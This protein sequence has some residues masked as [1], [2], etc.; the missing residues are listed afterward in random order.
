MRPAWHLAISSLSA[1][2]TR[3]ALLV[4]AVA[5]ASALTVAVA[6]AMGTIE[7]ALRLSAGQMVGL[8]DYRIVHAQA[9]RLPGDLL[10]QVRA[11]PEVDQA[12]GRVSTGVSLRHADN[13]QK[14]T[15]AAV[16]V[17]PDVD[18][19]FHPLRLAAGRAIAGEN[20]IVLDQ[21]V[22]EKLDARLG[23]RLEVIRFGTPI[24]L[25]VVGIVERPPLGV[26]Q[27]MMVYVSLPQAQDIAASGRQVEA[28]SIRL[29]PGVDA[30]QFATDAADRLPVAASL[31]TPAAASARVTRSLKVA[32]LMYVML[33][34]AVFLSTAVIILTGLTTA[35]A[36]QQREIAMVRCIGGSRALAGASRLLSGLC[37]SGAGVLLGGPLG[38]AMSYGFFL[39]HAERLPGGYVLDRGATLLAMAAALGAGLVG[40]AYPALRAAGTAPVGMLAAR[41]RK[42]SAV[43]LALAVVAAAL[44]I[45]L[46][47]TV[48]RLPLD[49]E[50]MFAWHLRVALPAMFVGYVLLGVVVFAAVA[51]LLSPL[52]AMM[53]RMPAGLLRE[54]A[55][56]TPFRHGLTA[57][58]LMVSLAMLVGM[59]SS[60]RSVMVGWF[61]K[62]NMPDAFVHS[63]RNLTD[64]QWQRLQRIDGIEALSPSSVF[65]VRVV[66]RTLGLADLTPGYTLYISFDPQRFFGM[67]DLQWIEGE[68][69]YATRRLAEGRALLISREYHTA[70]GLGVGDVMK[71]RSGN[72]TVDFEIVGVVASV[73]IDVAVEFFGL[74]AAY[75]EAAFS[76]VFGSRADAIELF[77]RPD[78]NLVLVKFAPDASLEDV[79]GAIKTNIPGAASGS[80]R[81]IR[82]L[83]HEKVDEL[84]R[85]ASALALAALLIGCIGVGHLV[86]ANLHARRFEYGVLR[87]VGSPR[88]LLAR[89]VLGE[90]L[91]VALAGCIT[92]A[93]LGLHLA[94]AV[95]TL[96]RLIFGIRYDAQPAWDVITWGS[97]VVACFALLA[98]LPAVWRLCATSPRS[99]L[100]QE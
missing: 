97:A 12:A 38:V 56:A 8:I 68:P 6:G 50:T 22:Q 96:R 80:S 14:V 21:Q 39:W 94:E 65:P 59:W 16:G 57:A 69:D 5:M 34:A 85:I 84:V 88:A 32:H 31:Q 58:G 13:D 15:L 76:C 4:L 17:E 25:T 71:L 33:T 62:L 83:A 27:R 77:H 64:D 60:T 93:L 72:E 41:A 89:L 30:Q 91:L 20:E 67:M 46:S 54:S 63:G 82:E 23:D 18:A 70:H 47:I 9:G 81:T 11:W 55:L 90:T 53:L 49:A 48:L 61:D 3:T 19:L 36:E 99:L 45:G 24:A 1:R 98:T 66:G 43:K 2:R 51:H 79:M 73:G 35:V 92:G 10:E 52:V 78:I 75:S 26:L 7:H 100:A 29:R 44:L 86:L 95:H 28:I 42:P 74:Q 87:A 40:A 37:V